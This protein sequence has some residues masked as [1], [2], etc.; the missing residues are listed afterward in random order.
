MKVEVY[1]AKVVRTHA[2][3]KVIY[4][5]TDGFTYISNVSNYSYDKEGPFFTQ[6]DAIDFLENANSFEKQS[7]YLKKA[8]PEAT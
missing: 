2:G 4:K 1:D 7:V 8:S 3:L 5:G 6:P